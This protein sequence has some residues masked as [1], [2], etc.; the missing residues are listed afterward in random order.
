MA[1]SS[2]IFLSYSHQ[3]TGIMRRVRDSL[4]GEGLTAWTDEGLESGTSSWINAIEEAIRS[5]ECLLVILTPNARQSIWVQRELEFA[6]THQ[7]R[8]F[9]V[10]A[11]GDKRTSV[12]LPLINYQWVDIRIRYEQEMRKLVASLCAHIGIESLSAQR[13]RLAQEETRR[14]R[15]EAERDQLEAEEEQRR[16]IAA[17]RARQKAERERLWREALEQFRRKWLE[18]LLKI[19]GWI[20]VI[21]CLGSV[22]AAVIL[23]SP[24][25][26]G[27]WQSIDTNEDT[28]TTPAPSTMASPVATATHTDLPSTS[29]PTSTNTPPPT[30]TDTVTVTPT[31]TPNPTEARSSTPIVGTSNRRVYDCG[32]YPRHDVCVS[33]ADGSGEINLTN[34]PAYDCCPVLSPDGIQ[35]LFISGRDGNLELFVVNAD[36]TRLTQLTYEHIAMVASPAWS[37][38]GGRIAFQSDRE[39]QTDIYTIDT[40]GL[41]EHQLTDSPNGD[42]D[43]VW[44]P[45]GTRILFWSERDGNPEIYVMNVDGTGQT[46][47]TNDP[48]HDRL[49][50]WSPDGDQ[51]YFT[52]DREGVDIQYVM[53]ADGS[54]VA[55]LEPTGA[56]EPTSAPI[57]IPTE[58]PAAPIACPEGSRPENHAFSWGCWIGTV[59]PAECTVGVECSD[60]C[61]YHFGYSEAMGACYDY[62]AAEGRYC[63]CTLPALD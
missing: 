23:Y 5:A 9:P 33:D 10:L 17:E 27:W 19:P 57:S 30:A 39:G 14:K 37:P 49:P 41:D 42:Y 59:S 60:L 25:G 34:N 21:V 52:S 55:R 48:A 44:S 18:R 22:A 24:L 2:H 16:L 50:I 12:P 4:A 53:N 15:E 3:D 31:D 26:I 56:A 29:T 32:V 62:M 28:T 40:G 11:V 35:I 6:N 47:L 43:P 7:V 58:T 46:R 61:V 51:I 45:D 20:W 36:G 8:I 63:W 13:E 1:E 54:G 38:D